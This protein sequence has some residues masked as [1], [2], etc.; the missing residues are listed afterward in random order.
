VTFPY[1]N[2]EQLRDTD[3]ADRHADGYLTYAYQLFPERDRGDQPG[4]MSMIILERGR[5]TSPARW[6]TR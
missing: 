6:R 3:P 4:R 2:I 5:S 1:R